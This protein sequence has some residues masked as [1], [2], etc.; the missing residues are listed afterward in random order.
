MASGP[1]AMKSSS[2][3]LA[4]PNHGRTSRA[5][6]RA[7]TKSSQSRAIANRS[8]KS[9]SPFPSAM[10]CSSEVSDVWDPVA[11]APA[12]ELLHHSQRRPG[13]EEGSRADLDGVGSGHEELDGVL[14]A[15]D[16]ADAHDGR[17]GQ[18][19]PAVVDG[20]HGHR[21]YGGPRQATPAGSQHGAPALE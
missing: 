13:L 4:T 7:A 5:M 16:T 8:R 2:P 6:R 3:T 17:L 21:A 10:G 1:D 12:F 18:R 9:L 15:A 14:A 20:P 19:L 11:S